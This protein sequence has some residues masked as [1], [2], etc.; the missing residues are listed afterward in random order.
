MTTVGLNFIL[1]LCTVH[2]VIIFITVF[3][4]NYVHMTKFYETVTFIKIYF[5]LL[6]E[7]KH[8]LAKF[9]LHKLHSVGDT[10]VNN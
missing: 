10:P 7:Q 3:F 9:Q 8:G 6:K 5:L 1:I 2:L 4:L